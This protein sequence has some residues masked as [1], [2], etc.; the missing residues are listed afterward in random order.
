MRLEDEINP[1][2]LDWEYIWQKSLKKGF[3]KEKDWDKIATEYGKWLE[4]D[5]YPDV[6]L[7]EMRIS[8]NDTVLDIGCGEGTITRKIAKK[9][10]SVT[11]I[12]KSELMLEELNKKA[13][14]ENIK[15][16]R[17]IQK[18]IND[19]SVEELRN[20]DIVLASRCLNGIANIKNTLLTLNE[21]ANNYVYITVFGSSTHKYKKEKAKIAG[22]PFKAGTDYMVLVMLLRSLGIEANVLQLECENLKEY[23]SIDEAIDRSIWRL[24][25]LEEE[26]RIALEKYFKKIFIKNERGNWV[27]PK[28]KTDLVLIWWRKKDRNKIK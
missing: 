11:G 24:G 22:K 13:K 18:D 16:I 1:L 17:T 15:N 20:Y 9:A 4:N 21:I 14:E 6:L 5:D 27:N 23:Y 28:D 26:N 8:S 10:K 12:D 7:N 2:E 25:H 19:L 3:K